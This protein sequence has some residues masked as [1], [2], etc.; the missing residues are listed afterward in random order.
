MKIS[1][2]YQRYLKRPAHLAKNIA[3][4]LGASVQIPQP[5]AP[6]ASTDAGASKPRVK[7]KKK[8]TPGVKPSG[9][10]A[11]GTQAPTS[12]C[13]RT[14]GPAPASRLRTDESG[15]APEASSTAPQRSLKT[16]SPKQTAMR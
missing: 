1:E 5:G 14:T 7:S 8:K 10:S 3:K 11:S 9:A 12:S 16:K 2:G 4:D 15:S 13:Q 6:D